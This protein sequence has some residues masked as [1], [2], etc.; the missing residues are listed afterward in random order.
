MPKRTS[1]LIGAL[2]LIYVAV[3]LWRLTDSCLWFDEIFSVHAAEHDWADMLRFV[4]Q[5]LVHPPLFYALLKVWIGVGGEGLFWLRLLPVGFSIAAIYPFLLLCR[6]LKFD[7]RGMLLALL[8]FAVNG[9]LIKYAQTLRM[10]SML[11]FL[12]LLSI[13]LFGRYFN[14]GKSWIWLVVVNVV[15]VYTHYFGW[16]VIGAEMMAI[17]LFQRIK[18]ARMAA[19]L[20][21]VAASFTPWLV[22]VWWA[23]S[24]GSD[25]GQNIAWQARPG[26]REVIA[27]LIDLAEPIYFQAS[28]TEP[29][30]IYLISLPMLL[31]LG[32]AIAIYFASGRTDED[33]TRTKLLVLFALF[34]TLTG[35]VISWTLPHSVWGTRHFIVVA[36]MIALMVANA[37]VSIDERIVRVGMVCSLVALIA[38]AAL[39]V[40]IR[41][42]PKYV[43]C[44][45]DRVSADI[46]SKDASPTTYTFENLVA[47]HLWFA[48]RKVGKTRVKVVKGV[49]VATA[50][51]AYFLPRGFH[52]VPTVPLDGISEDEFWLAFRPIRRSDDARLIEVFTRLGY[53]SCT[54]NEERYDRAPVFWLKLA[55]DPT[56]CAAPPGAK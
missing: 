53:T 50:D 40:G 5:D 38:V 19:M 15:L 46:A 7:A 45:W 32:T 27:F 34:P 12:S 44:A 18:F 11:M 33:K 26:V 54:R 52:D 37:V 28:N 41:E 55:K 1:I 22:A 4:A 48:D 8:F 9:S 14:R 43:W 49:D 29:G 36:P 23:A 31:L 30:S 10:Y 20:G 42:K 39:V 13:W 47:Y 56:R 51:D 24:N 25:I 6:E 2:V 17:L 3:R 35:F 21:I 16:L